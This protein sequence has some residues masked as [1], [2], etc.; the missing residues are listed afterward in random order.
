LWMLYTSSTTLAFTLNAAVA[1]SGAAWLGVGGSTVTDLVLPRM[2][3]TSSAVYILTLTLLGLALGPFTVGLVSDL[4]GDLRN[5]LV[6]ALC[7]N[8]GAAGLIAYAAR[9]LA[10]DER[11]LLARARAAGEVVG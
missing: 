2:R 9:Y 7:V 10:E 1:F 8:I 4:T 5:G 6:V 3:G 11:T